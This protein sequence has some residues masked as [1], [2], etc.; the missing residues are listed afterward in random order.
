MKERISIIIPTY[1]HCDDFLKPCIESI[2]N[3]T[4]DMTNIKIIVVAN[5][6]KDNTKE[7]LDSIK[8]KDI[9]YLWFDNGIGYTKATNEGI[10]YI[11][12]ET[13]Y[14]L[15]LNND[16][17]M[18]D[19]N[20]LK[21]LLDKFNNDN[22]MGIVGGMT[23]PDSYT[24]L[25]ID[26]VLF[27]CALIKKE[28]FE[29]I[30]LLDE[31]FNPGFMEDVD[32][33]I[34]AISNGFKIFGYINGWNIKTQKREGHFP[35]YHKGE[36]TMHDGNLVVGWNEQ[37]KKNIEIINKRYNKKVNIVTPTYKR[38]EQ[39]TNM[40]KSVNNQI[41]R[42]ITVHICSDGADDKVKDIV[43]N[44]N[45]NSN[46][47]KAIYYDIEHEG[48]VGGKPRIK[49]L[50]NLPDN[51]YVCFVD[52]DNEIYPDYVQKLLLG[53]DDIHNMSCCL[54][55]FES[56]GHTVPKLED[57]GKIHHGMIDSLNIM[58][59]SDIAKVNKHLWIQE[60]NK[61]ID[62]DFKF[63][64]ACSKM[65]PIKLI[66]EALGIH[67]DIIKNKNIS[68]ST[69]LS[70]LICTMD[71]RKN[72]LTNL[73][74]KLKTQIEKHEQVDKFS[75]IEIIINDEENLSIGAKRNILIS[76]ANGKY[77]VFIDD[78]DDISTN[79][80][81]KIIERIK[82][83]PDCIGLNIKR[84][85][86]NKELLIKSSIQY[87]EWEDINNNLAVRPINHINP[88]K[89]DL[90]NQVLFDDISY[91]EDRFWSK[92][93]H[94]LIKTEEYIDNEPLYF[95]QYNPETS[96]SIQSDIKQQSIGLKMINME[97]IKYKEKEISII[98][99]TY[100]K[101]K[102]LQEC[103]SSIFKYTNL[104][105]K[106]II[107]IAN[108]C[109][110]EIKNYLNTLKYGE[111][112]Q[113]FKILWYK[114]PLG[115]TKATNIGIKEAS[116]KY[117]ILL[118]SD[119]ILTK[120]EKDKWINLL[121]SPFI[122]NK[123]IG[124]SGPTIWNCELTGHSFISFFCC[125]IPKDIINKIG[126]LDENFNPGWYEDNDY[127]IRIIQNGYS[128]KHIDNNFP[129]L[130]K[131][132]QTKKDTDNYFGNEWRNNSKKYY[133]NKYNN[134]IK[135]KLSNNWERYVAGKGDNIT[136]MEFSRY[137]WAKGEILNIFHNNETIK[138]LE[139]GC[140]SGYGLNILSQIPNIKY[141]GIDY[142]KNVIN[143]AETQWGDFDNI[144]FINANINEI[145][146]DFFNFDVIIA[147]EF[148]EH[149]SNGL[150]LLESLKNKCKLLLVT[151]PKDE[152]KGALG[153]HHVLHNLNESNFKDFNIKYM[154]NSGGI[155]SNSVHYTDTS[156]YIIN[157]MLMKY[158]N[159]INNNKRIKLNLASGDEYFSDYINI[160]LYN[161]KADVK[162]DISKLEYPDN[163]ADEIRCYHI[164]EHFNFKQAFPVLTEWK[165]V[166]KN[167][168]KLILETPDMYNSCRRFVEGDESLR[169][170]LYGHFFAWP[171][172]D[173]QTHYFLYTEQQ[174]FYTLSQVG[175][176]NIK[177][178]P[179]DSIYARLNP[180]MQDLFLKVECQK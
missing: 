36:G 43:D 68:K 11:Y 134:I 83:N 116:G 171:W 81:E 118:N 85:M 50:E 136:P 84:T 125:M 148:I 143:Y 167:G 122:D 172:M 54:I 142:D 18:T 129:I 13:D 138:V 76:K 159:F 158:S 74:D 97:S 112:A 179:P 52:D 101:L 8:G 20:W 1:N 41:Y 26:F 7:Y 175:F 120:Q 117:L 108:G 139:I 128:I 16:T 98:I 96:L 126:I 100:S 176:K 45:K 99:P 86:N 17:M 109:N 166:L 119:I 57:L 27:Y 153:E 22:K 169:I 121:K 63:I 19:T 80:I 64:K 104:E 160:D 124:I 147:F 10:K 79:Y 115:Y 89:K 2:L 146:T 44:F 39:L 174:L 95:Y 62:H 156:R 12:N 137:E 164:L 177:R 123:N 15:L 5:G 132:E 31:I 47:I 75:N 154:D 168:G 66:P 102:D 28:V 178:L 72:L 151:C 162:M 135:Q 161:S 70:I 155:Y 165:R 65:T 29:K 127:S 149:I 173:G 131:E 92:E 24:G 37:T 14:F 30:G 130:H 42:N 145:N 25:N 48:L 53:I 87:K 110:N 73:L 103:L 157:L 61:P 40:L 71:S 58:I 152:P 23:L 141:T 51:E 21:M 140:S 32:F 133:I 77:V 94:H 91:G 106:E 6:C 34:K 113:Y 3:Q 67:K 60:P 4:P 69:D 35:C 55:D 46:D 33:N 150:S 49:I 82:K 90:A 59:K 78:D 170:K 88:I 144:D 107:I 56:F 114:N 163:Y 38:Y 180:D 111:N 93:I 9:D 105:D